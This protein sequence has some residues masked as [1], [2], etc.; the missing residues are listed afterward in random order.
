MPMQHQLKL[1]R[2]DEGRKGP[3]LGTYHNLAWSVWP[4]LLGASAT[5][6]AQSH[7]I[8][9]DHPVNTFNWLAIIVPCRFRWNKVSGCLL[10]VSSQPLFPGIRGNRV[11]GR[12]L[13]FGELGNL[14]VNDREAL[15]ISCQNKKDFIEK[16][17]SLTP[18]HRAFKSSHIV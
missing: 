18:E 15:N 3:L 13:V 5:G 6:V 7:Q 12:Y 10:N 8:L 11:R 17:Q 1:W 14:L 16:F 4:K 9:C 2:W